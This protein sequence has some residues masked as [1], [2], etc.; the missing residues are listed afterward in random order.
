MYGPQVGKA[1]NLLVSA[2]ITD[3]HRLNEMTV[4][5]VHQ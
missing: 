5:L 1:S 2:H 3:L 4:R